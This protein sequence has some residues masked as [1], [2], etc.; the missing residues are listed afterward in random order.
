MEEPKDHDEK[1]NKLVEAWHAYGGQFSF[2]V[3]QQ[4]PAPT[5]YEPDVEEFDKRE[6]PMPIT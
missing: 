5:T 2:F 6:L 1:L 3:S 4:Q